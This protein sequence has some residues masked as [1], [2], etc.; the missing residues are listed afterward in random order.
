MP[1]ENIGFCGV[2]FPAIGMVVVPIDLDAR[3]YPG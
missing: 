3:L 2:L 1:L